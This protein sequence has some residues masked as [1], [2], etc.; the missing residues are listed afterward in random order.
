MTLAGSIRLGLS[1]VGCVTALMLAIAWGQVPARYGPCP[2]DPANPYGLSTCVLGPPPPV[3]VLKLAVA[4]I[5]IAGAAVFATRA[6]PKLKVTIGAAAASFCSLCGLL[7]INAVAAQTFK[8]GIAPSPE[9]AVVVAC[10]FFLFGALVAWV[11]ARWWP[12]NSLE[13]T[14]ER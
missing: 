4:L 10:T 7:A 9:A 2:Q 1:F 13:R 5:A 6:A 12:N 8:G 11:T 14:R 3:L